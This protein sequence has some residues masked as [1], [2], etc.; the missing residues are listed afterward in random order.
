MG[1]VAVTLKEAEILSSARKS[2]STPDGRLKRKELKKRE[3]EKKL[4]MTV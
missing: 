3:Y 4:G 1:L 2:T